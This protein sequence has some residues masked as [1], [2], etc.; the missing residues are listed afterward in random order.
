MKL[1]F[2]EDM[3]TSATLDMTKF[4]LTSTSALGAVSSPSWSTTEPNILTLTTANT[5][6]NSQSVTLDIAAS[7]GLQNAA[8]NALGAVSGFSLTNIGATD[9]AAP[10]LSTAVVDGNTLTLTYDQRLIPRYP[11]AGDFTVSASGTNPNPTVTGVAI[12]P[13]TST[14]TVVLTLSAAVKST[15]TV[16]LSYSKD[17]APRLQ[18]EWGGQVPTLTNESVTNNTVAL[19][20][21]WSATLTTGPTTTGGFGC[22]NG[23]PT[24]CSDALDEDTFTTGGTSY[25]V[26][27]A[28]RDT[29]GIHG[30]PLLV[31][32][33]DKVI[34]QHWTLHVDGRRF[35]VAD[36]TLFNSDKSAR[37][38][39]VNI[40][41]W[42][43]SLEVSLCLTTGGASSCS[44]PQSP[45]G[46]PSGGGSTPSPPVITSAQ[47]V[48][49]SGNAQ[50]GFSLTPLGE[51]G[52]I[53]YRKRQIDLP[54]T[55]N[56]CPLPG[57]PAVIISRSILDRVYRTT[58]EITFELSEVSPQDPPSGFRLEGCAVEIDPGVRL[59]P[60]ETVTV[61]LPPTGVEGESDIHRYD[62]PG[63]WERLES[64]LQTVNGEDLLCAETG[65]FSLFG[66]FVPV[67]ESTQEVLHSEDAEGGFSLTPLGEGGSV[68]YG[69]RTIDLSVTRDVDLSSGN[70][71]VIVSRDILDR[72]DEI[73]FELR[74]VS[75]Q[76]PP[77]GFRL[78]GFTAEVD[79]GVELEE[80]ETVTVCL[81]PTGVEGESDI[82]RYD[83]PGEWERLESRLQTV[84]EEELLCAKTGSFSLFGVFV[85]V[86]ESAEGV[87]HSEDAEDGFS[88][89]PLGEGGSVVY[90]DRTIGLSV[91][92]DVDMSSSNPAVIVSRN[93][94]DRVEEITFELSEASPEAPPL[95]LRLEGFTAEVNLGVTLG[96][97]ET[98]AVCL[99][100]AGD[101]EDIYYRYNDE[102]EEWE[103][104]ESWVET[105]NG[106]ELVC[107]EAGAVSL[108]AVFVEEMG[109]CVIAAGSGE[110][111]V[112]WQGALF[113][114]LLI[115]SV[116]LLIPGRSK[117]K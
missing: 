101:E 93:V 102:S 57:N 50:D 90:G 25:Q 22:W 95:G 58:R 97:G 23:F 44:P 4:T 41:S 38:D 98:V 5:A 13:G 72:V 11:P 56:E 96:E 82:H 88:L 114:L 35:A 76:D 61:C 67:I 36:A 48:T 69:D 3:K 117:L 80:G 20:V 55:R 66:V 89:T 71:A 10:T 19:A 113:N 31:L 62:G 81:P 42:S 86:I 39:N 7:S 9:P 60:R 47:G 108:V 17:S 77:P 33:L 45:G 85:P 100:Y 78:E 46:S 8:G 21:I 65:S 54:I 94:L 99:P 83:G 68:V 32:E 92:G 12:N 52:S 37:W 26:I 63:E 84:N 27:R 14:S 91:T 6:T 64:Q 105:V 29:H 16:T 15:D 28:S 59:G 73:T 110:G 79:L 1:Y 87:L 53:V 18:N 109:G 49:H 107:A 104:L 115:I 24:E 43:T 51:E 112:R 75:P 106:E 116:L 40:G 34:S 111:T 70:P 74:E 103:L 30:Y 2:S